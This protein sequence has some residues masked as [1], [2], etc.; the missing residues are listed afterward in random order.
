MPQPSMKNLKPTP[1]VDSRLGGYTDM[2]RQNW[3]VSTNTRTP[4]HCREDNPVPGA[5]ALL[6]KHKKVAKEDKLPRC[7]VQTWVSC[8][9]GKKS[10]YQ[11]RL[12]AMM[13]SLNMGILFNLDNWSLGG[14]QLTEFSYLTLLTRQI[15]PHIMVKPACLLDAHPPR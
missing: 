6:A 15:T 2:T 12:V 11:R 8:L 5:A 13:H 7:A 14:F 9:I 1:R 3:L 4:G 10:G